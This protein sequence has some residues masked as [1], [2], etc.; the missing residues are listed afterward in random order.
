MICMMIRHIFPGFDMYYA[1]PAQPL[2][3]VSEKRGDLHV[4]HDLYEVRNIGLSDMNEAVTG[5]HHPGGTAVYVRLER[6]PLKE[7]KLCT[8]EHVARQG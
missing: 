1:G 7:R 2:T 3:T 4:D 6:P 5:G 8:E